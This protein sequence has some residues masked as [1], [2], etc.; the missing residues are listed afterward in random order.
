[1]DSQ[2]NKVH[3]PTVFCVVLSDLIGFWD[4]SISPSDLTRFTYN[5][6]DFTI[7]GAVVNE[8]ATKQQ[9]DWLKEEK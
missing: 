5:I 2:I 8:N 3:S 9:Y 1:M 6:R 4:A 7:Y